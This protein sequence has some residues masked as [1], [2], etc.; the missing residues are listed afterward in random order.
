M[1]GR[2]GGEEG[3]LPWKLMEGMVSISFRACLSPQPVLRFVPRCPLKNEKGLRQHPFTINHYSPYNIP[4]GFYGNDSPARVPWLPAHLIKEVG[5]LQW[6][7]ICLCS[8]QH[9]SR[10]SL[11][12][13]PCRQGRGAWL[14]ALRWDRPRGDYISLKKTK[15]PF[16]ID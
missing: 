13:S 7:E 8:T 4:I 14:D 12:R 3:K 11:H 15:Q 16:C 6:K 2:V 1:G 5:E 9:G 10:G